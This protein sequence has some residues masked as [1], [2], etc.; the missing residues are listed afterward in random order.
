MVLPSTNVPG[1]S[2]AVMSVAGVGATPPVVNVPRLM[3]LPCWATS[4]SAFRLPLKVTFWVAS[5]IVS[6]P[7]GMFTSSTRPSMMLNSLS[8]G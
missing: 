8:T 7:I 5:A 4:P 2:S 6:V 1:G 3:M